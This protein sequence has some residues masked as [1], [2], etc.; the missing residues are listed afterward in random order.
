MT[1]IQPQNT[2][3]ASMIQQQTLRQQQSANRNIKQ[4]EVIPSQ[5]TKQFYNPFKGS[6]L[7][8]AHFPN[9]QP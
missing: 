2:A 8:L 7:S 1:H 3:L 9:V 5:K 4:S 6:N